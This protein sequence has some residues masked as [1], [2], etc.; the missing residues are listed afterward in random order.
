M[1]TRIKNGLA[2]SLL[3]QIILV[4]W[5]GSYPTLVEKYYSEGVYPIIAKVLRILFGWIP[6]SIGDLLYLT[7]AILAIRFLYNNW[8]KIRNSPLPFARDLVAILAIIYF[9]FHLFWGMNYY[10]LPIG[11]KLNLVTIEYSAGELQRFCAEQVRQT[12][13]LHLNITN[14]TLAAVSLPY[15]KKEIY[16][17]TYETYQLAEK[18]FHALKYKNKS[19]KHSLFSLP[20]TYMGYGGYLNPF[21]NEAQVNHKIPIIRYPTISGHEMAHQIGYSSEGETNLIG[22]IVT[23]K[24]PEQ[25]FQYSAK[26]HALAYC[27]SDLSTRDSLAAKN[28]IA[29]LNPGVLKNYQEISDFWKRYDNPT[30]PIFKSIFSTFLK[31]N[32]QQ[33]GILSYNQVVG[34]LMAYDEKY[35]F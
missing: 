1:K 5:L 29:K 4:K 10:R 11:E 19:I 15:S 9:S 30:E 3:P 12:N 31:A 33:E 23:A 14:D 35:G 16:A 6:F 20:L 13:A 32:N 34:L 22:F 27:L 2:L 17:K 7:L 21:T 26:T 25:L 24:S 28:L 18:Q 8:K